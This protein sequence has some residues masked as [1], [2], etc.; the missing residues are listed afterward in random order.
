MLEDTLRARADAVVD[1]SALAD[2][3]FY[4]TSCKQHADRSETC[5]AAVA[6]A[7][8]ADAANPT[9]I[10]LRL[11]C[12]HRMSRPT[13]RFTSSAS[14]PLSVPA[15]TRARSTWAKPTRWRGLPACSS[16]RTILG[17]QSITGMQRAS[18]LHSLSR[19]KRVSDPHMWSSRMRARA[20]A[21]AHSCEGPTWRGRC[22]RST[23]RT[24]AAWRSSR[25]SRA[26]PTS[27][28][29]VATSS[30]RRFPMYTLQK[31]NFF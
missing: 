14:V 23:G 24:R 19:R 29:S 28:L 22:S 2:V 15:G 16:R 4:R 20:S 10:T 6:N 27:A 9:G 11:P 13:T 26:P 12:T 1:G 8:N 30:C 21:I 7:A 3:I 5:A 18:A 17:A 31:E 25:T